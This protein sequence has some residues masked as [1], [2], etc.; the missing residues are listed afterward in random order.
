MCGLVGVVNTGRNTLEINQSTIIDLDKAMDVQNH[1]GPDD[2][3][4]CGINFNESTSVS[5]RYAKELLSE[6][7]YDGIVGF[8]R[9]SIRDLTMAGHQPMTSDDGK[10]ILLFNGE[11]Y[12]DKDLRNRLALVN[13]KFKGSSDTETILAYYLEFGLDKML[14]VLNGMF[15]IVIIDLRYNTMHIIRD[16]MGIKPLYYSMMNN[17]IYFAS[18]LK[19]IIQFRDFVRKLDVDAFNSRLLFARPS[20]K[21]LL[22][23]VELVE[24]GEVISIN[25]QGSIK[26]KKYFEL[27]NYERKNDI[28]F[29]DALNK[30]DYIIG[31]CV[32]RQMVSDVKVGCQ[33]SGGIDSTLITYYASNFSNNELK[34]GISIVG[35]ESPLEEN[36]INTVGE[37]LNIDIH[38]YS[39]DSDYFVDNYEK[40]IWHNDA[41]VYMPHFS[42]FLKIG[43]KAKE[44]VT[45]LLSGEGA[46]E[47][48]GGYGRLSAGILQPF[49]SGFTP[50]KSNIN[51]YKQYSEYAVMK[52]RTLTSLSHIKQNNLLDLIQDE[53]NIFDNFSGSNLDK[54]LKYEL[55]QRL[56]EGLLRQDKM[57]MASSVENRV[58]LLDN[59]FVDFIMQLPEHMLVRFKKESPISIGNNPFDWL[60]G[61]YILKK[62][63]ANQFGHDFAFRDKTIMAIDQRTI[64]NSERFKSYF[65]EE[66][67]PSLKNRGIIDNNKILDLYQN[68]TSISM[69]DFVSLWRAISLET[70]CKLFLDNN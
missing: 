4:V 37:K 44:H 30:C 15:A 12:N 14:E 60:E 28:N 59:E 6:N 8:N 64:L 38:K 19:S 9:L 41:P 25:Y 29:E 61:K 18:E 13:Y 49:M 20:N 33:V 7:K 63:V 42:S 48:A 2:Q 43:E 55:T 31:D 40:M 53:I 51:S 62:L 24:P 32:K 1:R 5:K 26:K 65:Y 10:V 70:W 66:L 36:Y 16:R 52:E 23:G 45:V 46:D 47:I 34:D 50:T 35:N 17:R 39:V 11:I 21:V 57:T 54:H 27:D 22:S 67:Y 69:D 58:P 3:G 68:V 56:P